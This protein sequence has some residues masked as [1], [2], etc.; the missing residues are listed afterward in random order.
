MKGTNRTNVC[1]RTDERIK[2]QDKKNIAG[3]GVYNAMPL[4][5]AVTKLTSLGG[6]TLVG[7]SSRYREKSSPWWGNLGEGKPREWYRAVSRRGAF[8]RAYPSISD[9]F[10]SP[11]PSHVPT[12]PLFVFFFLSFSPS[13]LSLLLSSLFF[14]FV[15]LSWLF[16]GWLVTQIWC[17]IVQC[18]LLRKGLEMVRLAVL[19]TFSTYQSN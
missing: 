19:N 11:Y 4:C 7:L 9:Q 10:F 14:F 17:L 8:E 2:V 12:T 6:C 15:T 16:M 1:E 13:P 3:N 18:W 5:G